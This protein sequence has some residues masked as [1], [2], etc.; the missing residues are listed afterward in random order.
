MPS[1]FKVLP[2]AK[3]N[4]Q[5]TL[6]I[7]WKTTATNGRPGFGFYYTD[8][9][10]EGLKDA[11]VSAN[12]VSTSVF[13]TN[14]NKTLSYIGRAGYSGT[15]TFYVDYCGLFEGVLTA[16]QFEA[17]AGT[18]ETI[19]FPDPPGTV[20]GGTLVNN[21]DGTGT[22]VVDTAY[23]LFD[24]SEDEAW[25]IYSATNNYAYYVVGGHNVKER[26]IISNL[27]KQGAA[28][29]ETDVINILDQRTGARIYIHP[30]WMDNSTTAAQIKVYLA[31][32]NLQVCYE[33][34]EPET[35][36][37]SMTAIEALIGN[38]NLWIDN[39][40]EVTVGYWGY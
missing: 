10:S 4:T 37:L 11:N 28:A 5:Y 40:D 24:G 32:N 3:Q 33:L 23:M 36:T 14:S 12:T 29:S 39:A 31:E 27:Y 25:S 30:S 17:Y 35:Y 26:Q 34:A 13:V 38:Q 1:L 16:E 20:Y 18:T 21:G 2:P 19:T 9:T 7:K 15:K 8:G 6:I 22:L